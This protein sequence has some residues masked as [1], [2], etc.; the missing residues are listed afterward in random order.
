MPNTEVQIFELHM[1]FKEI[2]MGKIKVPDFQREFVWDKKAILELLESVYSGFPIGTIYILKSLQ[3]I[4]N[5]STFDFGVKKVQF[6]TDFPIKYVIDGTQRLKT[7]FYCLYVN[8]A[9]PDEFNVGFDPQGKKF[10]HLSNKKKPK[11]TVNLTSIFSSEGFLETQIELS[12]HKNSD[13]FLREVNHLF[14]SFR[15]YK[16][17]VVTISDVTPNQVVEIFQQLN[18]KGKSLTKAEISNAVSQSNS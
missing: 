1:L 7:L 8:D 12:K 14:S 17:P 10:I 3:N 5:S 2:E 16:I 4:F 15:H 18:T 6:S 9:K 13:A 11:Y